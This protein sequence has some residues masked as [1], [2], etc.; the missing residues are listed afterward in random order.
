MTSNDP[1]ASASADCAAQLR[2]LYAQGDIRY[3]HTRARLSHPR[4]AT[5]PLILEWYLTILGPLSD[6]S[7]TK[8]TSRCCRGA[9]PDGRLTSTEI[10]SSGI[11][12]LAG[13]LRAERRCAL[14]RYTFPFSCVDRITFE[15]RLWGS[16]LILKPRKDL[17]D[18]T[19]A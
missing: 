4:R 10:Y 6:H 15:G 11:R 17:D 16:G 18:E 9:R 12:S 7:R 13:N 2:L 19:N 1:A 5:E 3:T 8:L 14:S